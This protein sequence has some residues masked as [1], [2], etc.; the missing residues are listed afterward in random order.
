MTQQQVKLRTSARAIRMATAVG[1]DIGMLR[2]TVRKAFRFIRAVRNTYWLGRH[3]I[4]Y[5]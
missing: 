4:D 1:T 5:A 2:R 3:P